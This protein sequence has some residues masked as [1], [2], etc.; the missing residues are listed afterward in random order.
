MSNCDYT[1]HISTKDKTLKELF[2]KA[3]FHYEGRKENAWYD[4]ETKRT[5]TDYDAIDLAVLLGIR[6][7]HFKEDG[8]EPLT[9][10]ER[11]AIRELVGDAS[12]YTLNPC[13]RGVSSMDLDR[14]YRTQRGTIEETNGILTIYDAGI[15]I[16][17]TLFRSLTKMYPGTQIVIEEWEDYCD[18]YY[19]TASYYTKYVVECGT[20]TEVES[21]E[22]IDDYD[23]EPFDNC[24]LDEKDELSSFDRAMELA[25]AKE[26]EK[27]NE[28][29]L[30]LEN[31][32]DPNVFNNIGVNYARLGQ[33]EKAREYYRKSGLNT[34][35]SNILDL[36]IKEKLPLSKGEYQRLC[37]ELMKDNNQFGF[38]YMS[39]IVQKDEFGA[40]YKLALKFLQRGIKECGETSRLV[41]ELAF[42]KSE[43]AETFEEEKVGH[44]LYKSILNRTDDKEIHFLTCYNY[45]WQCQHGYGTEKNVKKAI[46]WFIYSYELG[47]KEAA[48]QL[49][50]V[51]TC[52]EGFKNEKCAEFWKRKAEE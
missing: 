32:N 28:I 25:N 7:S 30:S 17:E 10:E 41:F 1:T 46:D 9:D 48:G 29:L 14:L 35:K 20:V 37:V 36:Y 26:Y 11:N 43:I 19:S 23:E 27:S 22:S 24:E 18:G 49:A 45:A 39:K 47:F 16:D 21:K 50:Y 44:D 6:E 4:S 34:S 51:Y 38:I 5:R 13:C 42:L 33:F 3:S 12:A 31:T 2:K 52:E 8:D 40:D 15:A